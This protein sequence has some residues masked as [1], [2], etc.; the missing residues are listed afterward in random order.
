MPHACTGSDFERGGCLVR[1]NEFAIVCANAFLS[2]G[3]SL[4][5]SQLGKV[6]REITIEFVHAAVEIE[7]AAAGPR[8]KT[9]TG[10]IMTLP[11]AFGPGLASRI[12]RARPPD[13]TP[14][15]DPP[16]RQSFGERRNVA[17]SPGLFGL[18]ARLQSSPRR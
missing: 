17:L 7:R 3:A 6:G 15:C 8:L 14:K 1:R 9:S 13:A 10:F 2:L 16:H 11:L 4:S 18:R 12:W 5:T